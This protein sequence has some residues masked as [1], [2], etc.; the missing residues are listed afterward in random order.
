M[1]PGRTGNDL[2]DVHAA[3]G[4]A[5]AAPSIGVQPRVK[6]VALSTRSIQTVLCTERHFVCRDLHACYSEHDSEH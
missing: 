3:L 4:C 2:E 6:D 5:L 1:R